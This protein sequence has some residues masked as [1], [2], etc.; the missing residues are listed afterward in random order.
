MEDYV[1][2]RVI[3][4]DDDELKVTWFHR[5]QP[6]APYFVSRR[7][8]ERSAKGVRKQLGELVTATLKGDHLR[9]VGAMRKLAE[10]GGSFRGAFFRGRKGDAEKAK[11]VLNWLASRKDRPTMRISLESIL[12]FPWGLMYDGDE[13]CDHADPCEQNGAERFEGFWCLRYQVAVI[14]QQIDP[15]ALSLWDES[16]VDVLAVVN[17]TAYRQARAAVKQRDP[18][19]AKAIGGIMNAN[20]KPATTKANLFRRW[21]NWTKGAVLLYFY[22]HS[23]GTKLAIS[24]DE[25][26]DVQEW[27]DQLGPRAEGEGPLCLT[28]LN[29]CFTAAGGVDGGFLEV[30]AGDNFCGFVGTECQVPTLFALRFG[31]ELV[32]KLLD[33]GRSVGDIVAE[34]RRAHWPLSVLYS[35]NCPPYVRIAEGG[36]KKL[37]MVGGGNYSKAEVGGSVLLGDM[38]SE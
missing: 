8:L 9:S 19:V 34:M 38:G 14:Y 10:L 7:A 16:S 26:I 21:R 1:L 12:H 27:M 32:R 17:S 2:I 22:C 31:S 11:K 4:I 37:A 23:T 18:E 36:G 29:G 30:T 20:G 13:P 15:A 28:V 5:G 35:V 6:F 3:A 24:A 25:T 33:T